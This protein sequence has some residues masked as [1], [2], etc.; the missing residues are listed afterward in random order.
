MIKPS[1]I[2]E[3]NFFVIDSRH[4]EDVAT[5]FY[6]FCI[7]EEYILNSNE[8][9][10]KCDFV[11]NQQFGAWVYIDRREREIIIHQDPQGAFGL[12]LF[13]TGDYF[14]V[15]NSF[16][17]L[18]DFI[19]TKYPISLNREYAN[20]MLS[21]TFCSHF[22]GNTL[23]NEIKLL[24]RHE[25]IHIDLRTQMISTERVNHRDYSLD[26]RINMTRLAT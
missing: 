8:E 13:Q 3:K 2:I 19:K 5:H 11:P 6:G 18:V 23:I 4:L 7:D 24:S 25:K 15:S 26:S 10:S 1:E 17:M 9:M 12:Y 20:A 14:A 21:S 22:L 16:I